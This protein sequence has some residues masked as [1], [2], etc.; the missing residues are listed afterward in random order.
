MHAIRKISGK[1]LRRNFTKLPKN[2]KSYFDRIKDLDL[3]CI[4]ENTSFW[5]KNLKI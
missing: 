4:V 3:D 5:P 2:G 1:I